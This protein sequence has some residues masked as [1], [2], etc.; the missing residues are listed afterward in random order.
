MSA[1]AVSGSST[2]MSRFQRL[3]S[4]NELG[5]TAASGLALSW[6]DTRSMS[7]RRP[8]VVIDSGLG[9][10]TVVRRSAMRSPTDDIAYFGDTARLPYG[11]KTATTVTSFVKQIIHYLVPLHPRHVV[12]ACNTATALSMPAV[13]AAFP[14]LSVSGVI[15][16]GAKAAVI[17][18]GSKPVPIIGVIATEATVPL[19]RIRAG[20]SSERNHARLLLRPTP[21]LV[22][23]IEEGRGPDDPL[24]RL[25]LQQYLKALL[26][27]RID[28]LVLGCTHYPVYGPL[29]R[30]MVGSR[31]RVID[32][33]EQ[34][35]DDVARR[36]RE[37]GPNGKVMSRTGRPGL[38]SG[39]SPGS[40]SADEEADSS[41]Q[42][43]APGC[44]SLRCFVTDD[45]ARFKRLA[46]R[47]LGV[48]IDLPAWVSPDDLFG[49]P[50]HAQPM[51]VPA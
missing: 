35:A 26:R 5:C 31:V 19:R 29:I 21:L 41:E 34:C 7:Q 2:Q 25:A 12:I 46:P 51:S 44:G 4:D 9:G 11:S 33:A 13:R 39:A 18:A 49:I 17:A 43:L 37:S 1:D 8:I 27:H 20:N 28:V 3:R 47:F 15:E 45:P 38:F 30:E 6:T 22:P 10:L 40:T 24:V 14:G 16:P 32:S 23:I 50:D 42:R 48:E 36:L